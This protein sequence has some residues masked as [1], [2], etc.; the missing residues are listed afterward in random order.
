MAHPSDREYNCRHWLISNPSP[1]AGHAPVPDVIVVG[2]GAMGSAAA[3]HLARRGQR[4]LGLEAFSRG[5]SLGSSHGE[6]RVIRLAYWEHPD[7]VPLLRRAYALWRELEEASGEQLLIQTGG[8]FI[9]ARDSA[10]VQGTL[11]SVTTHALSH[12]LLDAD[13]IRREYPL[14]RPHESDVAIYEAP[15]GLLLPEKCVEAHAS[16]ATLNGADLH[17]GEAVTDWSADGSGV[18]V[19]TDAGTYTAERLLLTAGA[20]L[21]PL[22]KFDLP[23]Q[24]ERVPMFWLRPTEPIDLFTPERFP[25]WLWDTGTAGMFYGFPH[26]SWDGVKLGRHHSGVA[27]NPDS[28]E[29]EIQP[30]DEVPVRRFVSRYIPG[31][32]GPVA[33]ARVCMYTNTPDDHFVVDRHP[34]FSRVTYAGGFSGHGFK[35]A[36]VMGEILA[37][38][39]LEGRAMPQADFLRAHRFASPAA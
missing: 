17:Y 22:V 36:S 37:D 15:A 23:L 32:D 27:C 3:C 18:V 5:H 39:C 34:E 10:L 13:A 19:K 7:Y 9:G 30:S 2:L 4:V 21:K 28:V 20:W 25:I 29:R 12:T 11:Q 8:L 38:L 6:S 1:H 14:L 26:L 33:L 31:L 16:Q 35:F 24:P